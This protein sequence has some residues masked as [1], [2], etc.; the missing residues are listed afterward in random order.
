MKRILQ[1]VG[2]MDGG[3][4]ETWLMHVLR[5]IDRTRFQIDFLT[6]TDRPGFYDEEVRSLGGRIF[7]AGDPSRPWR[8]IPRL[9]S[10]L[11]EHGPYDAVHSHIHHFNGVVLKV[12]ALAGVPMRISHSHLDTADVDA[13]AGLLRTAYLNLTRLWLSR[14]ATL[15]LA[16]SQDAAAALYGKDWARDSRLRVFHCAISL[17]AF[18]APVDRLQLR[19]ELGIPE[20]AFVVGHV[21]R[22]TDQKNHSFLLDVMAHVVKDDPDA[23]ALLIGE[24]ELRAALEEKARSLGL[25][26]NILFAGFRTDI[27]RLMKG[28]MDLFLLPSLY[29]GLP[30]VLIEAQAA[31]L[32]CLVSDSVSTEADEV[33]SLIHR[34]RLQEGSRRWAQEILR[35][36][37]EPSA[38]G[39]AAALTQL[40]SSS[41]DIRS[42]I[43]ALEEI[44]LAG[45]GGAHGL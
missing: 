15:G 32:P 40:K 38:A 33:K 42:S 19:R 9:R 44:Y 31:G 20:S 24:G 18:D 35:I 43:R 37:K 25:E 28:A 4:V 34:L 1:G 23:R 2:V 45:D 10:L 3:G 7:Y 41:F 5:N 27:P 30:L 14:H 16:A 39:K 17:A 6:H 21:G 8:Y 26:R 13:K 22:L 12:A 36:R 11:K 29:E